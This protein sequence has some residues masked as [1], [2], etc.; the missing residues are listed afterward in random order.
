M[1]VACEHCQAKFKI[2]D[3][4]VPKNQ[5]FAITCPKC[6][7]KFSVA[8][9]EDARPSAGAAGEKSLA[10]EV[11]SGTYD[12]SEQ[13]FDFLEEGAQTALICI[14]DATL[15]DTVSGLLREMKY[16]LTAP[17]NA[18]EALKQMRF[19]VFDLIVI[20]EMFD[21]RNP[22]QNNI[23]RYME[24][25]NMEIRR[26]MFVV[27]VTDRFRTMDNMAAFNKSVNFVI[28]KS[29]I[30]DFGKILK[31][32]LGDYTAFYKVYRE[33]MAKAGRG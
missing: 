2:P 13:P 3:D 15:R 20:D 16:V 11:S 4:K 9:R 10:E 1:D 23:L 28:N 21:A 7:K 24:R 22:D 18:R 17:G 6:R 33:A 25:L 26:N 27:M 8:P 14:P 30:G 31:K 32:A 5:A 29:N 19:H 12:A